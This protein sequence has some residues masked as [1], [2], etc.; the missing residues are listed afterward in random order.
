MRRLWAVAVVVALLGPAPAMA[1]RDDEEAPPRHIVGFG[2]SLQLVTLQAE[3]DLDVETGREGTSYTGDDTVD[4]VFNST[5]GFHFYYQYLV[6]QPF[7]LTA[8]VE[9]HNYQGRFDGDLSLEAEGKA[10]ILRPFENDFDIEQRR[11]SAGVGWYFLPDPL[12][13]FV[14]GGGSANQEVFEYQSQTADTIA[15]TVFGGAG[16]DYVGSENFVVSSGLTIDYYLT[17]SFEWSRGEDITVDIRR[18]P[19]LFFGR[20]GYRF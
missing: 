6:S 12:R 3:A 14:V 8:A 15:Y 7:F 1:A 20:I 9:F 2:L 5:A 19:L 13:P 10:P 4:L 18:V 17:E 16:V 11:L